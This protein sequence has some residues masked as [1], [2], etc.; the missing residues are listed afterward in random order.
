MADVSPWEKRQP[1]AVTLGTAYDEWCLSQIAAE[2][3]KEEDAEYFLAR[4]YNYRNLFNPETRFFH[5]KDKDGKF[6]EGV[7][8][9]YSG[10]LG[11]R[12]YYDEIMVIFIVGMYNTISA[13]WFRLSEETRSLRL[14][15]IRC[16]ILL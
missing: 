4:S 12:D 14:L 7:D 6:I 9:R 10:G 11:A 2:L 15:S 8:Y 13:T 3:G 1:V 5:P 16:L